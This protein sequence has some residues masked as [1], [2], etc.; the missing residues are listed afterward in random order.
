MRRYGPFTGES[1]C[2]S[3]SQHSCSVWVRAIL[4]LL[5]IVLFLRDELMFAIIIAGY[6]SD[7]SLPVLRLGIFG[8]ILAAGGLNWTCF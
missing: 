7:N 2:C 5:A 6:P 1:G 4:G 8:L 3:R